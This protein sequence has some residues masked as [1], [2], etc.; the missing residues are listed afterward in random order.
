MQCGERKTIEESKQTNCTPNNC[1]FSRCRSLLWLLFSF[2]VYFCAAATVVAP[3]TQYK[4]TKHAENGS[5]GGRGSMALNAL[6]HFYFPFFSFVLASYCRLR[7]R[8][9]VHR[10]SLPFISF[11]TCRNT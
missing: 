9:P 1:I 11:P 7:R 5:E 6:V 3:N 10:A 2:E 8:R 4:M